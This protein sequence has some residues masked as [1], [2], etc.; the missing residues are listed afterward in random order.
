MTSAFRNKFKTTLL[1]DLSTNI[2]RKFLSRSVSPF[3]KYHT[4]QKIEQKITSKI[5]ALYYFKSSHRSTD[6]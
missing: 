5:K 4:Q 2:I 1:I 3:A 6:S